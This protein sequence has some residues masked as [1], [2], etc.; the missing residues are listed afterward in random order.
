M[1]LDV[2]GNDFHFH[3]DQVYLDLHT[4]WLKCS[5]LS[6]LEEL[7]I[8]NGF[9]CFGDASD[10]VSQHKICK[11][12]RLTSLQI[13]L[14]DFEPCQGTTLFSNLLAYQIC[15][16]ANNDL[17]RGPSSVSISKFVEVY[18]YHS[19]CLQDLMEICSE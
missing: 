12:S 11:L 1:H 14:R 19:T 10:T 13:H 18:D 9:S 3:E 4:L 5:N 8:P 15:V 16:G 6:S 17:E 2:E 7:H